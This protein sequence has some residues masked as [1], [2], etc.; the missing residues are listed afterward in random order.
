MLDL[1]PLPPSCRE[2]REIPSTEALKERLR[3]MS[4]Y[5]GLDPT[6]TDD[7]AS[8]M[9]QALD[10]WILMKFIIIIFYKKGGRRA[11]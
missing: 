4:L 1:Q 7:V 6:V 2:T 3:F 10:V 11:H 5:Q 8:F 9:S